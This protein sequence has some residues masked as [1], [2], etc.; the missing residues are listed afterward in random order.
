MGRGI[1]YKR[2][3]RNKVIARK[4]RIDRAV[5]AGV[6]GWYK[7]DGQ[8]SKGKIHCGCIICK[9]GKHTGYPVLLEERH[10]EVF[11]YQLREFYG[12]IA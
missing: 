9:Y 4:K 5:H 2:E 1:A 6:E 8:Y 12:A 10:N 3:M 7:Y 11:K